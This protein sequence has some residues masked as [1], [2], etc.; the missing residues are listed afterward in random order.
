MQVVRAFEIDAASSD[1]APQVVHWLEGPLATDNR[2][3][4][5]VVEAHDGSATPAHGHLGGQVIVVLSGRGFVERE[6]GERIELGPG[7]VLVAH[8]GEHHVHGALP[9][10]TFRHLTITTGSHVVPDHPAA[11]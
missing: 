6:D 11:G 8:P 1:G 4:L 9:G 3:D 7:D 5:G 2:L 10:E